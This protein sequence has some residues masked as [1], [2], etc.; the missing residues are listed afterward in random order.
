MLAVPAYMFVDTFRR[1]LPIGTG[2]AA[3]AMIFMVR[4][5]HAT[6]V[7]VP[8]LKNNLAAGLCRVDSRCIAKSSAISRG[9]HCHLIS[10]IYGGPAIVA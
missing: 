3:G 4:R 7:N 5:S 8:M 2:A 1:L 10:S 9:T 6:V